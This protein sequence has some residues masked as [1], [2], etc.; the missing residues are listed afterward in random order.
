[1]YRYVPHELTL[2]PLTPHTPR[3]PWDGGW[4]GQCNRQ[5]NVRVMG[6]VCVCGGGCV[7]MCTYMPE[8]QICLHD[9]IHLILQE[10]RGEGREL[11]SKQEVSM[12]M[13][14]HGQAEDKL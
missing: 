10:T 12:Y 4:V 6:R 14:V 13:C 7:M 3:D 5:C 9:L 8:P 1:M 11:V 2:L